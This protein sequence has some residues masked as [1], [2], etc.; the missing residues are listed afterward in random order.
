MDVAR[1]CIPD[2]TLPRR[3]VTFGGRLGAFDQG[4]CANTHVAIMDFGDTQL[5][6]ETRGLPSKQFHGADVGNIL[7]FD[8][9]IVVNK[10]KF[11]PNGSS[12]SQP[13]PDVEHDRGP[14]GDKWGNWIAAMRSRS[15]SDLNAEAI[16]AHYSSALCHLANMSIRLGNKI[17]FEPKSQAFGDNEAAYEVLDRTTE[18][19]SENGIDIQKS[20]YV[21][22]RELKV[23][24][25]NERIID[26]AEANALISRDYRKGFEVP[27]QIA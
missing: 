18:Y 15:I 10:D 8:E 11:F 6:F 17:P 3:V 21:L 5:I 16:E 2:A 26:D 4:E 7:H 25:K 27:A 22:G 24:V 23:D 20:G 13:V 1:W 14:G 9:G 19:L 12:E